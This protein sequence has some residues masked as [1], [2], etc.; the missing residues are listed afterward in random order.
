MQVY[1]SLGVIALTSI[2][3]YF[4]GKKFGPA[5][6]NLGDRLRL[7]RSVKGATFDAVSSSMPELMISIFSVLLFHRFELGIGTVA[8]SALFNLLVIPALC[9]F[10][11]PITFKASKEIVDRDGLFY[12]FST[13]VLFLLLYMLVWNFFIGLFLFLGYVLYLSLLWRDTVFHKKNIKSVKKIKNSVKLNVFWVISMTSVMGVACYF[14]VEHAII[15]ADLMSIHPLL[16]GFTVIA[17]ATSVPDA[18][19]SIVNSKKGD[20]DDAASNVFGSNIFDIMVGVG[21]PVMIASAFGPVIINFAHP[22]LVLGLVLSAIITMGIF[23]MGYYLSNKNAII[24]ILVYLAFITYI[25]CLA[26]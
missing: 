15:F 6:S 24:L 9:V 19:I 18:V 25:I 1:I 10:A 14:M 16:I 5:S 3:I 23:R 26:C 13:I 12:I 7:P 21:V 8:G 20:V 4:A 2:I 11:A 17:A 22:E